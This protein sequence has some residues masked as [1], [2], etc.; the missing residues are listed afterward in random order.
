MPKT[1][2]DF[3][4]DSELEDV[5]TDIL[6]FEEVQTDPVQFARA[7]ADL[8]VL[9]MQEREKE[10]KP[11]GTVEAEA[12]LAQVATLHPGVIDQLVRARDRRNAAL[13]PHPYLAGDTPPR[14]SFHD[15][16]RGYKTCCLAGD[17][18]AAKM[19]PCPLHP[20]YRSPYSFSVDMSFSGTSDELFD[21]LVGRR[22]TANTQG[23]GKP[24]AKIMR[25]GKWVDLF[26][27]RKEDPNA[28]SP[29]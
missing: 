15:E 29:E 25:D 19:S 14:V 17:I 4:A 7:I 2:R 18:A 24:T 28:A 9:K 16:L 13:R 20:D 27:N 10:E 8:V 1:S 22:A 5:I 3:V 23:D 6:E 26:P 21:L 12:W 11:E